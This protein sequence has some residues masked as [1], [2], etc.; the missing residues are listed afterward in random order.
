MNVL[1]SEMQRLIIECEINLANLNKLEERL[2]TLHELFSRENSSISAEKSELLTELWTMLGGNKRK[3]RG[4]DDHLMLLQNMGE[5]RKQALAHVVAALQTLSQMS[6]DMDE[7]RVRVAAP[8]L[9]GSRIPMEV[10]MK[11]IRSGLERLKA[12]RDRAKEKTEESMRMVL[13]IDRE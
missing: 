8:D 5:Y 9:V 1:A 6:E 10:H 11:S 3:L 2:H 7:L 4:Y 13:G 12:G